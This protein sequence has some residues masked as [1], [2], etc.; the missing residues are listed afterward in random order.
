ME[1][2]QMNTQPAAFVC[3]STNVCVCVLFYAG[4]EIAKAHGAKYRLGPEL[5][6]W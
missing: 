6:I 1:H 3:Q 2:T 5:E 4:V